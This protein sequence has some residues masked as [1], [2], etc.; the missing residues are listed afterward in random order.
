M[1]ANDPPDSFQV[2]MGHELTDSWVVTD[3]RVPL[4]DIYTEMGLNT[5]LPNDVLD[6]VSY[7]GHPYS[8]PLNIHRANVLWFNKKVFA[9]HDLQPPTTFEEFFAVADTLKNLGITPLAFGNK[10]GFEGVQLFETTALGVMGPEAY[11]GLWTGQ[12]SWTDPRMTE[13]LNTYRRLLAYTNPNYHALTW[14]QA[15]DL[16]ISGKAAMT[17]MGDWIEGDYRAKRF[18]DYGWTTTPGTAGV[19][20]ALSDTFG[21]PRGARNIEQAKTWLRL[22]G[23]PRAQDAF[24][25]LKGS[26]PA[27]VDA[28]NGD[29]GL[30]LRSAIQAWRTQTVV[31]SLA[32]GAA[33]S[34]SWVAAITDAITVFATRQDVPATEAALSQAC[35][36]ARVCSTK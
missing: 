34:Q 19:Y 35:V 18:A 4:D 5:A 9:D 29:Y 32:H 12:T 6:I 33:A 16:V 22:I 3:R 14:D 15:N 1:L 13:T 36:D 17:I 2:H 28:G 20:D 31:P 27:N 11:R 24:N 30:Y 7:N 21:L 23:T 10:E 26:V 25:P 8:V